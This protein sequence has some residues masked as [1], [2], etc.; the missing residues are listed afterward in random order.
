MN[1]FP[2]LDKGDGFAAI[3]TAAKTNYVIR[4]KNTGRWEI[5]KNMSGVLCDNRLSPK[6]KDNVY[7]G[8]VRSEM[9]YG[10]ETWNM[11][12]THGRKMDVAELRWS[13]GHTRCDRIRNE[14]IKENDQGY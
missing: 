11:K 6:R 13:C 4:G 1:T 2:S 14:E 9:I 12:K 7:K 5:P 10:A 8:A 3:N